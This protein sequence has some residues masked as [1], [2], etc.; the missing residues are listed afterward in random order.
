MGACRFGRGLG[1][2]AMRPCGINGGAQVLAK[3]LADMLGLSGSG[4]V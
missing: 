3:S 4:F 2:F 1:D